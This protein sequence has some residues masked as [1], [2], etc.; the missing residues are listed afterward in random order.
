MPLVE[1]PMPAIQSRNGQT[2]MC[3]LGDDSVA[4]SFGEIAKMNSLI[5]LFI[6]RATKARVLITRCRPSDGDFLYHSV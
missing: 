4:V 3:K 6:P 2:H 1:D 5:F